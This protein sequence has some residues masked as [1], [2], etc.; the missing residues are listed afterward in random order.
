VYQNGSRVNEAFGD[1]V[2][3]DTIPE[4]A[5]DSIQLIP[6]SN[7]AF[8]LNAL[9]GALSVRMKNGFDFQ[10]NEPRLTAARSVAGG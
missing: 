8:G 4:F 1:V 6:G 3:W 9:G 2:Q 10:G 5:I 7:P